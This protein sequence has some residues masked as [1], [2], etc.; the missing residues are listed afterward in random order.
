M[1][2]WYIASGG[3]PLL[4]GLLCC[5]GLLMALRTSWMVKGRSSICRRGV[6]EDLGEAGDFV[7]LFWVQRVL[8]GGLLVEE[9]VLGGLENCGRVG[10]DGAVFL[11]DRGDDAVAGLGYGVV[12]VAYGRVREFM[13]CVSLTFLGAALLSVGVPLPQVC[14][15]VG[16]LLSAVLYMVA[17][18]WGVSVDERHGVLLRISEGMEHFP[19]GRGCLIVLSPA[20]VNGSRRRR[21]LCAWP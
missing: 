20:A 8:G 11:P 19:Q 12:H 15:D 14:P 5:Q 7:F 6:V 3:T 9:A 16:Y 10:G 2:R 18:L 17:G 1:G 13:A 21:R 4:L